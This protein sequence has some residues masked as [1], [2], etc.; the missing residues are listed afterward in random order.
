MLQGGFSFWD[1]ISRKAL[2]KIFLVGTGAL[3]APLTS[4]TVCVIPLGCNTRYGGILK[5]EKKFKITKL[6]YCLFRVVLLR[7]FYCIWRWFLNYIW[8]KK[9][10]I[11]FHVFSKKIEWFWFFNSNRTYV[12]LSNI[13]LSSL[14]LVFNVV[15]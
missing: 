10:S 5:E 9:K 6:F 7:C 4:A 14:R 8:I 13:N 1:F 15:G 12:M 2:E 3:P 11:K